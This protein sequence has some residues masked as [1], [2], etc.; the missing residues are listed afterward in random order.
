MS[1]YATED[2]RNLALVGHGNAGKTTLVEALLQQA[3]AI[4]SMGSVERRNTLC[5]FDPQEKSYQHSLNS[6]IV[7]LDYHSAHINVIDTPGSPDLVGRALAVLP[8]VETAVVVLNAQ[9][10]IEVVA[11]RLMEWA[12][13][14]GLACMIV[15]NQI[16]VPGSDLAGFMETIR[17][18]FGTECLP[19]NLPAK[20]GQAVVDCFFEPSGGEADFIS[21]E[22]AHRDLIDQV[23]EVD[24]ELMEIYLEQGEELTPEQLHEPFEKAL[25]DGH[26]VPVCFVSAKTGTGIEGLLDIMTRLLPNPKEGNPSPFLKATGE[27]TVE[28]DFPPNPNKHVLAHVFKVAID[29]FVGKLGIF[30]IHQG[31]ITKESQLFIGEARKPFRVGHLFKLFGKDH[32]EVPEGIPGDIC[33]V[34]KVE[35]IHFGAL[36]HNAQEW[37]AVYPRPIPFPPPMQGVAIEAKSRGDEQKISE[38]LR[39]LAAEDPSLQVEHSTSLNETVIRGLGDLHLRV[40]LEALKERYN[41]EAETH[42]PKI[43]YRETITEVSEGHHRHKKQTGGAGQFGEVYLRVEPLKRGAGFEFVDRIVGGVI[44]KQF[45]P[46]VEKGIHQVL[47]EGAVAGYPMQDIQV[48]LYDGK[49]HPVDSK[50]VAFIAAGRKAFIDAVKK[51]KPIILEPYVLVQ[52]TAP[53]DKLGDITSDLSGRRGRVANT[54]MLSSGRTAIIGL[55]PLAEVSGYQSKLNSITGGEGAFSMEF[56]HYDAVPADT[57]QQLVAQ[58]AP[59]EVEG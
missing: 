18:N 52:I 53:S 24:E 56:S 10:G 58:F 23:V 3:G 36:L 33:A 57:Q 31:T 41:V 37:E 15:V 14:Q 43:A 20:S 39:K 19:L 42:P 49:H 16:D 51:A 30:R 50:E 9:E 55:V 28:V 25:R 34:T 35:D 45:I 38:T 22:Q 46:A 47:E 48:T 12:K 7:G 4:Q 21:V 8:A 6:A 44:P 54:R 11:Q 2:I 29:P 1:S 27:E 5:D 26:L 32:S 13:E 40:V 59:A 17:A